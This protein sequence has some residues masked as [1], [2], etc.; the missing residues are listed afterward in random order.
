MGQDRITLEGMVFYGYHGVKEEEKRLGQRFIV[1]VEMELDLSRAGATD[2]LGDTVD[3]GEVYRLVK[4][5]LEGPSHN[6]LES[7]A[8]EIASRILT[9]YPVEGV[10]VK[11]KKPGVAIRGS[12]LSSAGVEVTRR[13]QGV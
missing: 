7:L 13:P 1:D 9:Q 3:Y 11:V 2:R 12:I 5:I 8:Q 10:K 6:L 4:G